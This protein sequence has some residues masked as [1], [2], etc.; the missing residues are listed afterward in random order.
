MTRLIYKFAENEEDIRGA[1]EVKKQ[2]F[3][4]EQG[5]AAELVFEKSKDSTE[6]NTIVKNKDMVIGTARVVF[7]AK[8]TAKIERMAVLRSFR[9][10]GIGKGIITFLIRE[11][12]RRKTTHIILHAQYQVID[13]YRSCGF[14]ESGLPFEEAGI[15]HIKMEIRY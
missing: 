6:L 15:K 4:I 13:F 14:R 11:F 1:D 12:K 3:I 2:V 10:K 9:N 5:I 8:N 7:P